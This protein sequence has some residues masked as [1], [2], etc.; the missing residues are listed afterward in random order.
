M[1]SL[2]DR[3]GLSAVEI[4]QTMRFPPG[5]NII[6]YGGEGGIWLLK[7]SEVLFFKYKVYGIYFPNSGRHRKG[8][9]NYLFSEIGETK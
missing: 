8:I 6:P 4:A 7:K 1:A 2:A 9:H 3:G 5:Q